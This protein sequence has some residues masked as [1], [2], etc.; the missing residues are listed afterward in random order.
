MWSI[1]REILTYL[2]FAVLIYMISYSNRS[3]NSY[4]EV[5]HLQKYL[6]NPRQVDLDYTEVRIFLN[7]ERRK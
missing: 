4:F 7:K 6:L 1:I 3:S 5:K 2:S